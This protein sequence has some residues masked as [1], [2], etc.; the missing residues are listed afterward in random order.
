MNCF[1][2][3]TIKKDIRFNDI[4]ES[5]LALRKADINMII[6]NILSMLTGC[7]NN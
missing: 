7:E 1:N 4:I 6:L 3:K 2:A 5:S